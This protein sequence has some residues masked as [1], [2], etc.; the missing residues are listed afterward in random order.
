MNRLARG[1]P[2]QLRTA[3]DLARNDLPA[4]PLRQSKLPLG[5][6]P[7]CHDNACGGRP[8]MKTPGPCT[9]PA[10][11]HAWAAATTDP[12][13]LTS[14]AWARAWR[15]AEAVAYH[16]GGAG[17]TVLDLDTPAAVAWARATLPATVTVPTTRGEH[18]IY[19]GATASHNSVLPGVDIKSRAAYTRWLGWG[20]GTMAPLP[21]T[22]PNLA[23]GQG[24]EA[25]HP[26][27]ER[28]ASST[29]PAPWQRTADTGCRHTDRY[30][31]SGLARGVANIHA[32]TKTGAGSAAF[33]AARFL[34]AQHTHCPGPCDLATI[35]DHLTTAAEAVGVPHDYAARAVNNGIA[36]AGGHL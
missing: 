33:G 13:V 15:E 32:R 10:P 20:T 14:T 7:T 6:C 25:N 9:C 27:G 24:E 4:L 29:H 2:P 31:T 16:P 11:C 8:N 35:A 12:A 22:V 30:L 3:L 5:N 28:L 21:D 17:L 23:P 34:A 19:R 18:W 36:A 1:I 26:A